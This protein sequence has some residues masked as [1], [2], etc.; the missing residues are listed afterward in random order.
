MLGMATLAPL[1]DLNTLS[2]PEKNVLIGA[3]HAQ[4]KAFLAGKSVRKDSHNS[5]VP[6]SADGLNKKKTRSLRKRALSN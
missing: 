1:P 2:H 4:V 6:P 5:S 3:L